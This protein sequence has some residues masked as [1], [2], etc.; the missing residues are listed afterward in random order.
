MGQLISEDVWMHISKLS[1]LRLLKHP[2]ALC[3]SHDALLRLDSGLSELR[4]LTICRASSHTLKRLLPRL[5]NLRYFA[6]NF[7]SVE[8]QEGEGE[9]DLATDILYPLSRCAYLESVALGRD[10]YIMTANTIDNAL[11]A[12]GSGCRLLKTLQMGLE[13][14]TASDTSDMY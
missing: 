14:V 8:E 7:G 10:S 12:L 1:R 4:Y 5:V 13:F 3:L 9:L 11:A 2:P 6:L